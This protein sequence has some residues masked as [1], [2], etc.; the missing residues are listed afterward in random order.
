MTGFHAILHASKVYLEAGINESG[1]GG[2][3]LGKVQT[4]QPFVFATKDKIRVLVRNGK[5]QR[6][7]G[8]RVMKFNA[9][10]R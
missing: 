2:L 5:W 4:V 1:A 10:K 9:Y 3:M 8:E 7:P 6:P